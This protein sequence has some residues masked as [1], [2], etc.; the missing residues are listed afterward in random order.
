VDPAAQARLVELV[1]TLREHYPRL[2]SLQARLTRIAETGAE[3]VV[4]FEDTADAAAS[5]GV[6]ATAC[7]ASATAA[8]VR[9]AATVEVSLSV[10]VEVSASV[11]AE[12]S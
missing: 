4:T 10:S 2:L 8:A 6:A 5:F 7:F 12:A 1:T 11:T 3:L 9:A